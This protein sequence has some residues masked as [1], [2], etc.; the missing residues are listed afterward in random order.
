MAEQSGA[1]R[2]A[3]FPVQGAGAPGDSMQEQGGCGSRD[4]QDSVGTADGTAAS[5]HRR[6]QDAVGLELV[7]EHTDADDVRHR[8]QST[9][10]R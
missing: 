10:L 1:G 7:Q 5:Y 2:G 4:G 6:G 3:E 9:D 8:V